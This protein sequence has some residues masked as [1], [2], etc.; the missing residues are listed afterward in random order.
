MELGSIFHI[1]RK[2]EGR[3]PVKVF[4]YFM[5]ARIATAVATTDITNESHAIRVD[6]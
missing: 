6:S 4:S 5:S 3:L 2:K 1:A